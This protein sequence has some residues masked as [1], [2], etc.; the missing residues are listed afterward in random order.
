MEFTL[1]VI[2]FLLQIDKIVGS[3]GEN[4]NFAFVL[5]CWAV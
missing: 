5:F 2:I 4:W 1:W 3:A